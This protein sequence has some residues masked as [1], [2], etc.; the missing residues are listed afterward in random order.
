MHA[1]GSKFTD[2]LITPLVLVAGATL[3]M[4]AFATSAAAASL[5]NLYETMMTIRAC[6][7][8]VTEEDWEKLTVEIEQMVSQTNASS[9]SVNGI[10]D[11]IKSEMSVNLETY[12]T[13]H[14]DE[15][16]VVLNSL[17]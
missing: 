6:E 17:V 4:G 13:D 8:V 16:T 14:A 15:V 9:D 1:I 2:K 12:C 5:A 3:A 10:F 11:D 7:I